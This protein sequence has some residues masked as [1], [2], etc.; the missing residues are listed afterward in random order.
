MAIYVCVRTEWFLATYHLAL[1]YDPVDLAFYVIYPYLRLQPHP[2]LASGDT[3]SGYVDMKG[4]GGRA[5]CMMT[6]LLGCASCCGCSLRSLLHATLI[7]KST[8]WCLFMEVAYWNGFL[9]YCLIRRNL[10]SLLF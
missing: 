2:F 5:A 1:L 8:S 3:C 7:N 6:W 9:I 4:Y 10:L